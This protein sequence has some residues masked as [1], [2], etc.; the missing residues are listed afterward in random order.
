VVAVAVPDK[1]C[2]PRAPRVVEAVVESRCNIANDP[3]HSLLVLRRRSLHEPTNVAAGECQV[4]PCV[5]EVAKAPHK[6]P[7]LRSVHLLRRAVAAQLQ[8]LLHQFESLVAVGEP[9]HLNDALG[10]GGLSKR[11]PGVALMHLDPQVEGER[12]QITHLEGDLHLF[13]E[14][15]HLRILGAGDHQVVDVDTHQQG[16]SS[17]APSVDGRLVRALPE[18]YPLE[19][20]VQLGIPRPRYLPQAIEG[21]A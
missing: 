1:V 14:R 5:G 17:I 10:V 7:V 6:T 19:C 8:P 3:P 2:L 13:L 12:P 15:C 20:G 9:S 11:D 4:Q 18:A 21:L 16:V